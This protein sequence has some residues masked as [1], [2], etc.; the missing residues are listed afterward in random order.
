MYNEGLFRCPKGS[1]F[2][3]TIVQY[4]PNLQVGWTKPGRF[5]RI[6]CYQDDSDA[7]Y[8]DDAGRVIRLDKTCEKV[9]SDVCPE[10]SLFVVYPL[11]FT[12]ILA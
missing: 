6:F 10:E 12:N 8:N 9:G 11:T 5:F 1:F 7:N 4:T 2:C 3:A